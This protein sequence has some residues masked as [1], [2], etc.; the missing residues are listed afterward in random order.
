MPQN[1]LC[2]PGQVLDTGCLPGSPNAM[3][4]KAGGAPSLLLVSPS[5]PVLEGKSP[6][7]SQWAPQGSRPTAATGVLQRESSV[8]KG[9]QAGRAAPVQGQ[10]AQGNVPPSEPRSGSD[11]AVPPRVRRHHSKPLGF[12]PVLL[13]SDGH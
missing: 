6:L 1:P 3:E 5:S 2:N 9:K 11:S 13:D 7:G 10:W 8:G 4:M 12:S